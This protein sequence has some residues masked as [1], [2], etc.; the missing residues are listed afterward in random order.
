MVTDDHRTLWFEMDMDVPAIPSGDQTQEQ[1]DNVAVAAF[2]YACSLEGLSQPTEAD[3][4][5][6][7]AAEKPAPETPPVELDLPTASAEALAAELSKKYAAA[8]SEQDYLRIIEWLVE[9]GTA[10]SVANETVDVV[11][12][13]KGGYRMP[14][15]PGIPPPWARL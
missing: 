2:E 15:E 12:R 11:R 13:D 9:H 1:A 7:R 6:L 10:R 3:L 8:E 5:A 4:R 14:D